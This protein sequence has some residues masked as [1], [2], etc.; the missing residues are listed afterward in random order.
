MF[1]RQT[2]LGAVFGVLLSFFIL[3]MVR[4]RRLS[5]DFSFLWL[6][7]GIAIFL[8]ATWQGLLV[9]LSKLLGSVY[10]PAVLLFFAVV[11]LLLINLQSCIRISRLSDQVKMLCQELALNQSTEIGDRTPGNT[12]ED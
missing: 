2:I 8:L 10:P 1:L 11:F 7:A 12:I 5:E 4:R 6:V 9:I 3:E